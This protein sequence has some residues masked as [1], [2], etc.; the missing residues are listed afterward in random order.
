MSQEIST[1]L[2]HIIIVVSLL[3][4]LSV[5]NYLLDEAA[6]LG[7]EH[8]QYYLGIQYKT[9]VPNYIPQDYRY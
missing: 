8:A 4:L 5:I 2:S 6:D 9:G 3:L 1:R 7:N